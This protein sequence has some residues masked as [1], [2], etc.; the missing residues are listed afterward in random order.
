[1]DSVDEKIVQNEYRTRTFHSIAACV[2]RAT[3]Q[4][5]VRFLAFLCRNSSRAFPHLGQVTLWDVHSF[6]RSVA[7]SSRSFVYMGHCP[8]SKK[9]RRYWEGVT[10]SLFLNALVNTR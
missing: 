8:F 1:M 2:C 3:E 4:H 9:S 10:P 7:S 6:F 5:T